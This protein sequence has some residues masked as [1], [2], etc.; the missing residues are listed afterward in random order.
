MKQLPILLFVLFSTLS[1][2]SQQSI[3]GIWNTGKKHQN[4]NQKNQQ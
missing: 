1:I 3:E 2:N 4:Q